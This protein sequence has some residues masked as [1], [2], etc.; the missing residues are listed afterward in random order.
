[1]Q[2]R[3]FINAH[4]PIQMCTVDTLY[5]G[6]PANIKTKTLEIPYFDIRN[7]AFFLAHAKSGVGQ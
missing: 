7:P 4:G 5:V 2:A 3:R 1:M 6:T